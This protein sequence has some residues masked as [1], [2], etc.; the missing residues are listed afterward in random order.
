[1]VIDINVRIEEEGRKSAYIYIPHEK[2]RGECIE[3]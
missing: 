3:C 1:M 2:H